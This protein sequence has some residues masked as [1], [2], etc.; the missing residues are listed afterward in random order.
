[1]KGQP[2]KG[3]YMNLHDGET[4]GLQILFNVHTCE[5]RSRHKVWAQTVGVNDLTVKGFYVEL[6]TWS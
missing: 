1:M 3:D 5:Y 6:V 2:E 4:F